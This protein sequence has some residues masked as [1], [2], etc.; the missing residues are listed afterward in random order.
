MFKGSFM[1]VTRKIEEVLRVSK[2]SVKCMYVKKISIKS[3]EDV[4]R[5]FQ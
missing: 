1:V 3:F 2:E 5:I 4:S